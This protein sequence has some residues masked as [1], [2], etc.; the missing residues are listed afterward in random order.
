[1]LRPH[2]ALVA[3]FILLLMAPAREA[4]AAPPGEDPVAPPRS[5][6]PAYELNLAVD[7]PV[8]AVSA[9]MQL[10]WLMSSTLGPPHCEKKPGEGRVCDPSDLWGM[11]ASSAGNYDPGWAK[12]SDIMLY[13]VMGATALGLLIEEGVNGGG[14]RGFKN[15]LNDL[16]VI[17][18]T[19]FISN[20]VTIL[21]A[22]AS[23]R[24]R[25]IMYGTAAPEGERDSPNSGLSFFSG[26]VAAS[27]AA[28]TA[29]FMT[30]RRRHPDKFWPWLV[31]GAGLALSSTIA[32]GRVKAG[33]HF[34]TDV[35][36]GGVVGV[37]VGV[38]VPALHG[39]PVHP[40]SSP[41]GAGLAFVW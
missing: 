3:S 35:I 17:V 5:T 15:G 18:E 14:L 29:L 33:K 4:V 9:V 13:S 16:L 21:T 25:P 2:T 40:T 1:M 34:P 37:S 10:G 22:M 31:L 27:A 19:I 12:A 28:S 24:P 41:G 30:L 26:H 11:D 7:I 36:T 8:T 23:R 6:L 20:A 38:A 39:S 32:V